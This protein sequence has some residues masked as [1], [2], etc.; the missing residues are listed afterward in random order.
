LGNA[1]IIEQ[2]KKSDLLATCSH[3][4]GEFDL[5]KAILFDGL[6]E[7][8]DIA[9]QKKQQLLTGLEERLNEL[10]KREISAEG[11]EKKAIEVG[12][13]KIIEKVVPAYKHFNVPLP[14]CRPLFEP[15]DLIVFNGATKSNVDSIT[16]LEIKTGASRL[17]THQK[18]VKHAIEDKKVR[19]EEV[20]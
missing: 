19:Y 18:A 10:K 8:P 12:I 11:A 1:D 2:L 7:Y 14:D 3:C 20:K 4:G 9:E 5:A 16:F 13:G 15:I 17:N 6:G